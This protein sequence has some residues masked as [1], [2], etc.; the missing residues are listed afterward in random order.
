MPKYQSHYTLTH[1]EFQLVIPNVLIQTC[2]DVEVV[3]V[4]QMVF[5]QSLVS[6]KPAITTW[7]RGWTFYGHY[8]AIAAMYFYV[9]QDYQEIKMWMSNIEV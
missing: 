3:F 2:V 6:F 9:I 8:I 1:K 4:L 7:R 5:C